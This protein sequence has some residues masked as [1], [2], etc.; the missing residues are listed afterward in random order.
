MYVK[1]IETEVWLARLISLEFWRVLSHTCE[2]FSRLFSSF[3]EQVLRF[4]SARV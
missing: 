2:I 4:P 3:Q 1:V